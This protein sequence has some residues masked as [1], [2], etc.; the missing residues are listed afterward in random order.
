MKIIKE[1]KGDGGTEKRVFVDLN[2]VDAVYDLDNSTM[3]LMASGAK[4][5][6]KGRAKDIA[7]AVEKVK[8]HVKDMYK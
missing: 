4:I 5:P 3:L 2:Q 1:F 8:L 6:V 7:R